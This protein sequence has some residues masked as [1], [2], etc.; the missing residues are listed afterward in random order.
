MLSI[1]LQR[2]KLQNFLSFGNEGID[3]NFTKGLNIITGINRDKE[4]GRNGVGKSTIIDG[5]FF[6]F[7]G[8]CLRDIKIEDI[9]HWDAK[10]CCKVVLEFEAIKDLQSIKYKIVRTL[11]PSRAELYENGTNITQTIGQTKKAIERII[12]TTPE[13]FEQSISMRLNQT[14]PFLR[15]KPLAKKKFIEG[16]LRIG[17]FSEMW[18]IIKED[19]NTNSK[20]SEFEKARLNEITNTFNSYTQQQKLFQDRK[21]NT[22]KELQAKKQSNSIEIDSL[23]S[24]YKKYDDSS[25][26]TILSQIDQLKKALDQCSKKK[27]TITAQLATAQTNG[28]LLKDK[29]K[30]LSQE[31]CPTC[32]RVFDKEKIDE[33]HK[34]KEAC[35][36]QLSEQDNIVVQCQNKM[37]ELDGI[38]TKVQEE[39]DKSNKNKSSLSL[40]EKENEKYNSLIQ[41]LEKTN[42]QFEEDIQKIL[43]E[44]DTYTTVLQE[45]STRLNQSTLRLNSLKKTTS[46]LDVAKFVVSEEGVRSLLIKKLL[47]IL[48]HR[49]NYYLQKLDA[50][51]T[52]TFNEYFE[53]TIYNNRHIARSYQSFSDGER[54]R[55][56]IAMLF[57]FLDLR[58]LQSNIA[59][60]ISMYDELLDTSLDNKGVENVLE[61]LKERVDRY[62]EAVYVISHKNEAIKHTTGEVIYLEKQNDTTRR[63]IYGS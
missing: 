9:P 50:N 51:C 1:N 21:N 60:N 46:I 25:Y 31:T 44:T 38:Q 12:Q 57:T 23:K 33:I 30:G 34:D 36:A 54:K 62:N 63:I 55:I 22:I 19:I 43:N 47:H 6:A 53:E 8:S 42:K 11:N 52:C 35:I 49:L 3:L 26:Q 16:I 40:M 20:E 15:K 45:A 56:D 61:I 37:R 28:R 17:I 14:E 59:I 58:R 39:L 24:K 10:D 2:I 4:D 32:R 48:N 27:L 18:K 7:F 13:M 5:V 29:I 41:Q